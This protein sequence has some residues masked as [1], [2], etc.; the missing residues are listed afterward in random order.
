MA[1]RL[2][3]LIVDPIKCD[4]YGHC[5]EIAPEIIA[6]DPWGYP[7]IRGAVSGAAKAHAEMAVRQCPRQALSIKASAVEANRR[8][9]STRS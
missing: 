7:I 6:L 8:V 3:T 5:A 1:K 4:A 9:G 2:L